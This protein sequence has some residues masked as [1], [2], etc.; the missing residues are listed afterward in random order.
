MN[1]WYI[2]I[3]VLSGLSYL[4]VFSSE[5]SDYKFAKKKGYRL[6]RSWWEI[7]QILFAPLAI[8]CRIVYLPYVLLKE[9]IDVDQDCHDR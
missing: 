2:T 5:Y 4:F 8:L 3:I 1:G 6:H 9:Y 7:C